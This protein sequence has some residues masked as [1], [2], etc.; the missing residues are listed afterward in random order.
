MFNISSVVCLHLLLHVNFLARLNKSSFPEVFISFHGAVWI[1]FGG[2]GEVGG[3]G[4]CCSSCCNQTEDEHLTVAS[5]SLDHHFIES[6][7]N[8]WSISHSLPFQF[9][10]D[11]Y[12]HSRMHLECFTRIFVLCAFFL[13]LLKQD[14]LLNI[15]ACC[16]ASNYV[17]TDFFFLSAHN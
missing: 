4:S 16:S 9:L 13:R 8:E 3:Q 15:F 1:N 12:K 10:R 2:L 14:E 17:F 5:F 6:S 7:W 11:H